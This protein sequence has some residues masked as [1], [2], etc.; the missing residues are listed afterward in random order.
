MHLIKMLYSQRGTLEWHLNVSIFYSAQS[1]NA[2]L[3]VSTN[4][5]QANDRREESVGLVC[6]HKE[7]DARPV[8]TETAVSC[9]GPSRE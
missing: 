4:E 9:N 8:L 7:R 3:S 1:F 2:M 6:T 5:L